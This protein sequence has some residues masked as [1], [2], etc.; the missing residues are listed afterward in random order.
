MV[1][2]RQS[3]KVS[4]YYALGKKAAPYLDLLP[5]IR[6]LLD[7][8]GPELFPGCQLSGTR[9]ISRCVEPPCE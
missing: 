1:H 5:M 2:S 6:R 8:Y 7:S 3:V 4:A 9:S